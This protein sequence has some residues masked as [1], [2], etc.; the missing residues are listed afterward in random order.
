MSALQNWFI[1]KCV[2]EKSMNNE[3]FALAI[4]AKEKSEYFNILTPK[5]PGHLPLFKMLS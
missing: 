5:Y 3:Q 2:S 4:L 1:I